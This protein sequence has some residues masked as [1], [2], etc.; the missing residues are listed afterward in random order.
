MFPG[1]ERLPQMVASGKIVVVKGAL[2]GMK[3]TDRDDP[4]YDLE[5]RLLDGTTTHLEAQGVIFGTG[6]KTGTYPFFT[7]EQ[8]EE[9]GM[10]LTYF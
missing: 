1:P 2:L 8:R 5:V 3:T 9:L 7:Q 10:P 4:G 6:W